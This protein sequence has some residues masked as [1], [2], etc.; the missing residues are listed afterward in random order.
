M[1][2]ITLIAGLA[3]S[4]KSTHCNKI[5]KDFDF[6]MHHD[7][8]VDEFFQEVSH[9]DNEFVFQLMMYFP[10]AK[11][12]SDITKDNIRKWVFEDP[13]LNI[14]YSNAWKVKF[15]FVLAAFMKDKREFNILIECPFLDENIKCLKDMYPN[16]IKIHW[17]ETNKEIIP[18][19]EKRGWSDDRIMQSMMYQ[20]KYFYRF[21]GII[22]KVI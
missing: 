12:P 17:M 11:L 15:C 21:K 1:T 9:Y 13:K 5:E 20:D 6:V 2:N 3:G 19:L 4:G 7:Q 14:L 10:E 16:N 22:D 18:R 8:W